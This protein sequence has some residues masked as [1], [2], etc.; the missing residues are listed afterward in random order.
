MRKKGYKHSEETKR[1]IREYRHTDEAK[2]KIGNANRGKKHYR[3][4]GGISRNTHSDSRYV[5]WR[6]MVYERDNWTC[7]TCGKRGVEL[8]A[9]HIKEWANYPELRYDLNN[10]VTLCVECHKLTNNYKGRCIVM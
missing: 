3:W 10:G 7:Q 1:K 5:K 9:H 6:S 2:K 8:N 4:K